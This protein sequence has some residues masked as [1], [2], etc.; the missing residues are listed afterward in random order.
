MGALRAELPDVNINT[1][2]QSINSERAA[3]N[4]TYTV[5]SRTDK[6]SYYQFKDDDVTNKIITKVVPA[7]SNLFLNFEVFHDLGFT[8]NFCNMML[9]DIAQ[10]LACQT[11]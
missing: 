11:F 6:G 10:Y 4:K 1:G 2:T 8:L 5:N 9:I 7:I 3:L